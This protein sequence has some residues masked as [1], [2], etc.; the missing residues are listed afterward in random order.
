M[1][2]LG[3]PKMPRPVVGA[4]GI[5][6]GGVGVRGG[7]GIGRLDA[8]VIAGFDPAHRVIKHGSLGLIWPDMLWRVKSGM[9]Q[10]QVTPIDI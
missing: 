8:M 7:T 3:P 4:P 9:A 10:P 2:V 1:E 5:G 6:V